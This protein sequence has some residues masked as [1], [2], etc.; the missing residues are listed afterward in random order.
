MIRGSFGKTLAERACT[1]ATLTDPELWKL[2]FRAINRRVAGG[3]PPEIRVRRLLKKALREFGL[4]CVD[5]AG[6]KGVGRVVDPKVI[7]DWANDGAAANP[8]AAGASAAPVVSDVCTVPVP[9]IQVAQSAPIEVR[10][11]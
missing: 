2:T 11:W 3:V 5:I 9:T 6:G 7:E 1:V 4:R 8:T 10:G